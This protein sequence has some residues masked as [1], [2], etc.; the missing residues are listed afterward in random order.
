MVTK[1]QRNFVKYS[2][3]FVDDKGQTSI[4]SPTRNEAPIHVDSDPG[5]R[6]KK[7]VID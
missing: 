2:L 5:V 6:L 7:K 1:Q 4:K 3:Y